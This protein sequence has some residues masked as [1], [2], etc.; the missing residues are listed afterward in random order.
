MT[1]RSLAFAIIATLA[2]ATLSGE[3]EDREAMVRALL[4]RSRLLQDTNFRVPR[5]VYEQYVRESLQPAGVEAAPVPL[6]PEEGV[7]ALSL[8][9]DRKPLLVATLR[10]RVF[11]AE[12]CGALPVLSAAWAWEDLRLNGQP[13]ELATLKGWLCFAPPGPG[14]YLLAARLPLK[15]VGVDG[16]SLDIAIPE[17]VRTLVDFDSPGAWELAVA[18]AAQRLR[19]DAMGGTRGRLALT[20]RAQLKLTYQPP[21]TLTERPPRYA[22]GGEV[23]WNL[24]AAVQQVA[25]Q[26]DVAIIGGS[27]ERLDVALPASAERVSVSGPDVRETQVASGR[28]AIFLRGR[29]AER[30]RLRVSYEM[31]LAKTGVQ[32]LDELSIADGAWQR[33]TLVVTNTAG[34]TEVLAGTMVGLRPLALADIPAPARGL[35]AGT[36][37]LA[38]EISGRTWS[39]EVEAINLGEFAL[40]ESIAD[41]AHYTLAFQADGT[42]LCKVSFEVRNRTKQFLRLDLPKGSIVLQARVNEA[43]KPV[44]PVEG[45]QDA[46]LLPLER[47]M[48]SVKG[49]VSFPVDVVW[50]LRGEAL[51]RRGEAALPLPRIDLPIAY[52]WCEVYVPEGVEVAKWAGPLK[53]VEK[54]SNET[55]A[56]SLSYGLGLAAEGYAPKA[57]PVPAGG[58]VPE[59]KPAEAPERGRTSGLAVL[60]W[61]GAGFAGGKFKAAQPAPAQPAPSIQP[62]SNGPTPTSEF[63]LGRNYYRAGKDFYE[64]GDYANAAKSLEQTIALNPKSVEAGNAQRLLAN[65]KLV[66]GEGEAGK[67]PKSKAEKAAGIQVTT[68]QRAGLKQ[69]AEQQQGYLEKGLEAAREGREKEAKTQLE[70]A[71]SLSRRLVEQGAN[72]EEQSAQL[73]TAREE[74][75]KL[76][77]QEADEARKLADKVKSLEGHGRY[78]EA[79]RTAQKLRQSSSGAWASSGLQNEIEKL[80]VKA[81]Q[82]KAKERKEQREANERP[83]FLD[84][85]APEGPGKV[86]QLAELAPERKDA[87]GTLRIRPDDG[88][89]RPDADM[90]VATRTPTKA[91]PGESTR[92]PAWERR[93]REALAKPVTFDFI[94][95]PLADVAAFLGSQADVTMVVDSEAVR[96]ERP[97]ITLR[98][99]D[100]R[101]DQALNWITKLAGLRYRIVDEAVFITKPER[102]SEKPVIRAY[103][104]TDL[105]IDVRDF[106]GQQAPQQ[107]PTV[108]ADYF[109]TDKEESRPEKLVREVQKAIRPGTWSEA[110]KSGEADGR[111]PYTIQ[112]R[113]GRIVVV[114]TPEVHEQVEHL[115]VNFRKARG[116]QVQLG[117]Q[118]T[119]QQAKGL[120]Q[121]NGDDPGVSRA[122]TNMFQR[123][124]ARN[125]DWETRQR[126][127][128]GGELFFADQP[129]KP[130]DIA[131]DLGGKLA[132]NLGQKVQVNSINIDVAAPAA[133][134]LGIAFTDGNNGVRYGLVDEAQLRTLLELDASKAARARR[135]APNPSLQETIVGTGALLANGGVGNVL[136][137]AERGNTLDINGNAIQLA[138]EKYILINNGTYLTAVQ[139]NPMQHWTEPVNPF[140]FVVV[141]QDIEV[142]RAG[143]LAKFE[144]T[145]V[146]PTDEM[147][148]RITY[149]W[150]GDRR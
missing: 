110:D 54:Y 135:A 2:S 69:L 16:G 61:L 55:A 74:L 18:D 113:N 72:K 101:A 66:R 76:R 77:K 39:A 78:D 129:E 122:D 65:I 60:G 8:P 37:A 21:V 75:S 28:A 15:E 140:P 148:I 85:F 133:A 146:E 97:T 10:L 33:G 32:R 80:A 52:A 130:G 88:K 98:V 41:L 83:L 12:R 4:E 7:Y 94:E 107:K 89:R 64:R 46:Y 112:Y 121:T 131:A 43:S 49:L 92:V 17:T 62:P 45:V 30:T 81:A 6:I 20:R 111:Q 47:S 71:E 79:L 13:A 102:L 34:G 57:R 138:H 67:G 124:V 109:G 106:R 115:L 1:T 127:V 53:H 5:S 104:V 91:A 56:A 14:E 96:D 137:A 11:D 103:D 116:P 51:A 150:K 48:A 40:R 90:P 68:E 149:R 50:M 87:E 118:I 70:A 24:D 9:A 105:T 3:A 132:E 22:L 125:Y 108:A 31:P 134:S 27:T 147:A 114:H 95:T 143:Q 84:R 145:L 139:A 99:R 73:R 141:S 100:M 119:T 126:T 120:V 93:V 144:K 23:A 35:M 26:L 86:R 117:E 38:Y 42:I 123:F 44:S 136:F 128:A 142:P 25:A 58:A 82:Q 63:M 59:K 29:I 36:P 19:G